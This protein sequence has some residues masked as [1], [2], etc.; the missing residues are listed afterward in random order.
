ME[1]SIKQ[2][3][4]YWILLLLLFSCEIEDDFGKPDYSA[5]LGTE[6]YS[7]TSYI[8]KIY[9]SEATNEIIVAADNGIT[10]IDIVT[11]EKRQIPGSTPGYLSWLEGNL[12]YYIDY[13]GRLMS[14]NIIS[15]EKK[16]TAVDSISISYNAT[17][18]TSAYFAFEKY[19]PSDEEY[20]PA[21][22]LYEFETKK[23][24]F[25]TNGRPITFSPE[26]NKLLF[27]Q[28]DNSGY[29]KYFHYDIATKSITPIQLS[30]PYYGD[31]TFV[32]TPNGIQFYYPNYPLV[33]L[34]NMSTDMQIGQ[35]ESLATPNRG[36]ISNSGNKLLVQK[37]KCSNPYY[38]SGCYET[39]EY[40]SVIDVTLNSETEMVYGNNLY[41]Y[42]VL[43][44]GSEEN[45]IA[46]I[47]DNQVYLAEKP[48]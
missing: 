3:S 26:G 2:I 4:S 45:N 23:E 15:S 48:E 32:W 9:W 25:I 37:E 33:I 38:S 44:L 12:L 19:R 14:I 5:Y 30:D 10:A 41:I 34:Y 42:Q 16:Q 21:L 17:P 31:K 8:Q 11:K 6:L 1:K 29:N 27:A 28:T 24:T 47:K 35:W 36:L 18:F 43:F 46:Y 22:F 20:D 13:E 7:A 40:Y 39:K